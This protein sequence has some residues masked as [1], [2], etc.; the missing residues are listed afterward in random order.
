MEFLNDVSESVGLNDFARLLAD[1]KAIGNFSPLLM[2]ILPQLDIRELYDELHAIR[3]I[4]WGG[5]FPGS[6]KGGH[7]E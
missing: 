3:S 6:I 5:Y 7:R 2:P 1:C 4:E